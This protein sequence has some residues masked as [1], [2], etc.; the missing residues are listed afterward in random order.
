MTDD[1]LAEIQ[2]HTLARDI[3]LPTK[4]VYLMRDLRNE[5]S[6][7]SDDRMLKTSRDEIFKRLRLA[8]P[9]ERVLGQLRRERLHEGAKCIFGGEKNFKR[10]TALAH[11]VRDDD[12]WFD[13][14]ITVREANGP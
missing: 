13:F 7:A 4:A 10:E 11:F 6:A 3:G 12:A 1:A 8:N 5:L 2:R 14:S 9:P